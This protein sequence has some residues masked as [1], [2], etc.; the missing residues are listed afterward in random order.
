MNDSSRRFSQVDPNQR[1]NGTGKKG[2]GIV[3][4]ARTTSALFIWTLSHNLR[5]HIAAALTILG[6]CTMS[7]MMTR[8]DSMSLTRQGDCWIILIGEKVL[9]LLHQ[10]NIFNVNEQL[11]VP[12]RLQIMVTRDMATTQIE[13]SLL[14]ANSHGQEELV[15]FVRE[16]LMAPED[17]GKHKKLRDPFRP[18]NK[19][20]TFFSLYEAEKK[21]NEKSAAIKA[22]RS[23]LHRVIAANVAGRKLGLP[24]IHSHE[25]TTVPLAIVDTNDQLRTG[26]SE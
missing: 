15:T 21:E 13:E 12:E 1:L 5:V 24:Q 23:I 6:R 2:G 8:L 17:D 20:P 3:D 7:S 9:E 26:K 22:D 11:T 10:A 25:L 14:Q 4:I 18:K 19:A 16:R